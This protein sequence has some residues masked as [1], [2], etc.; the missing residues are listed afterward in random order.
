[1][2]SCFLR[3]PDFRYLLERFHKLSPTCC[4][5]DNLRPVVISPCSRV[6]AVTSSFQEDA[7]LI[8]P[9]TVH[10]R[11]TV[12]SRSAPCTVHITH[13]VVSR[14]IPY[15]RKF[16]D[17]PDFR[18]GCI[19]D[20]DHYVQCH[21]PLTD[22]SPRPLQ[23]HL[24]IELNVRQLVNPRRAC[25]GGLQWSFGLSVCMFVKSYLTSGV[26]VRHENK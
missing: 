22:M 16:G 5:G 9:C 23:R 3:C 19:L 13:T 4:T 24:V 17:S 15:T 12:V 6:I 14:S 7:I 2:V 10:I 20:C 8:A 21:C 1:M 26:S 25:A 18:H 11:R